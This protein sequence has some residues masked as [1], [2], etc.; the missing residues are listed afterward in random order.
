MHVRECSALPVWRYVNHGDIPKTTD[1]SQQSLATKGH[2]GQWIL[3]DT[4]RAPATVN[5]TG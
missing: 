5:T 2:I 4:V 3:K 1:A